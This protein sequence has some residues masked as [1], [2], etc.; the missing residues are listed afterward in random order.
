VGASECVV[1][2]E[3]ARALSRAP[4]VEALPKNVTDAAHKD[5][6]PALLESM[7]VIL[8]RTGTREA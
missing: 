6:I 7:R 1:A 5:V 4:I 8:D 2:G 3:D